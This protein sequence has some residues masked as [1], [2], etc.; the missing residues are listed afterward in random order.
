MTHYSF[1]WLDHLSGLNQVKANLCAA[2]MDRIS[3]ILA[4]LIVFGLLVVLASRSTHAL[5]PHRIYEQNCGRCHESHAG[6]FVHESL[7][8]ENG[9]LHGRKSGQEVGRFLESGH[10]KLSRDP[11]LALMNHM[12][13]IHT[14]G[15]LFRKKC[16]ICHDRAVKLARLELIIVDGELTGRYTDRNIEEFLFSHGGLKGD[17]TAKMIT[18]LKRHLNS[19]ERN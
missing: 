12:M 5:D 14:S 15:A 2:G 7:S 4:R 1:N 19:I 16:I 13:T 11:I 10:G 9:K 8:I 17:E 3:S 6:D 18:V